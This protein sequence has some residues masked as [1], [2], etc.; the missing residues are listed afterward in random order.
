MNENNHNENELNDKSPEYRLG[1]GFGSIAAHIVAGGIL[2]VFVVCI[3]K[4]IA[5]IWM[6]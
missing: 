1:Y 3:I 6:L 2:A 4:L 5:W